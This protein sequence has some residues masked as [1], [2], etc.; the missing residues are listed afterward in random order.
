MRFA[1]PQLLWLLLLVPALIVGIALRYG[2]RRRTLASLGD[3]EQVQRLT[4]SVSHGR[5][6]IKNLLLIA[7]VTLLI[8]SLARP[9]GGERT[10]LAPYVGIDIVVALDFSKSMF[11]RDAYPSRIERAKAELNRLLDSLR[12]D[13]IGLVAF[14]G[15]TLSYPLTTDY[16]AAKL[17]W[18]HMTPNDMPVGG[19]AI[20]KAITAATRLLTAVRGKSPPR[21]QVIILLTDGEDHESEPLKAAQ[22]AGRRGIRIYAVGIGSRSGEPIPQVAEDGT[23]TGYLQQDGKPVTSHLDATTLAKIADATSGN[24]IEMDPKRFGVEP[25]LKALKKLQRSEIK[26]RLVKDYDEIF[27]WFLLPAL[28]L[29]LFDTSLGERRRRIEPEVMH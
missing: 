23:V 14:A 17:F 6:L 20:G 5:R 11:A 19:T 29:L 2:W 21:S 4:A 15:E 22:E 7:G 25:I 24:Y 3:P 8:L 13:R 16:A 10:T 18:R 1:N 28:L 9:Q 26:S 12:G 27:Q